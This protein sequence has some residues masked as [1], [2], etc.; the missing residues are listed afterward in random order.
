MVERD[1]ELVDCVGTKGVSYVRTVER[2]S[3]RAPVAAIGD[4]AVIR[5]I[6]KVEFLDWTPPGGIEWVFAHGRKRMTL[7]NPP[8]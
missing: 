6:G 7:R 3:Y 2:D 1:V 8:T 4:V 5:D